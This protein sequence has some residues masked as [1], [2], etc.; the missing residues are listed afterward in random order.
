MAENNYPMNREDSFTNGDRRE[1]IEQSVILKQIG[2]SM[3]EVR[4]SY[5]SL[6]TRLRAQENFRYFLLGMSALVSIVVALIFKVIG[7]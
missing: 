5:V 1:L 4:S 6:E 7:K 2:R 3:E